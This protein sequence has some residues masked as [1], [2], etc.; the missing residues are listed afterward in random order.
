MGFM[1]IIE[2][3]AAKAGWERRRNPFA[4]ASMPLPS[5]AAEAERKRE[6]GNEEKKSRLEAMGVPVHVFTCSK[7]RDDA[8]MLVRS[9]VPAPPCSL[10]VDFRSAR[11]A[12]DFQNLTKTGKLPKNVAFAQFDASGG[13]DWKD[14]RFVI[15]NIKYL[16]DGGVNMADI[17]IW[18]GH[19]RASIEVR[20]VDG[21][22]RTARVTRYD[23]DYDVLD[24]IYSRDRDGTDAEGAVKGF[25]AEAR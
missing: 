7:V 5:E 11:T 23:M 16:K 9:F 10:G 24:V 19:V 3:M 4:S 8:M 2:S 18:A 12:I 6:I 14:R 25:L 22:L 13:E 17:H 20:P 21:A 1:R 15:A